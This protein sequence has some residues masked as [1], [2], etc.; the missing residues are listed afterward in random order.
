M[1]RLRKVWTESVSG[2]RGVCEHGGVEDWWR[3]AVVVDVGGG[4]VVVG[5][6]VETMW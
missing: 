3:S 5:S 2:T 6:G 4:G 1:S